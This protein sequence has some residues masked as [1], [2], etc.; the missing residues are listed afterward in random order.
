[1]QSRERKRYRL[2]SLFGLKPK[3][4]AS[5]NETT[6]NDFDYLTKGR[7]SP[8]AQTQ[9]AGSDGVDQQESFEAHEAPKND[10][11]KVVIAPAKST[12]TATKAI[13]DMN[14]P[15]DLWRRA[16]QDLKNREKALVETF[17]INIRYYPKDC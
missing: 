13:G 1:M 5:K 16:Y 7:L 11:Y 6:S 8:F 3:A 4:A 15:A 12:K 17:E 9:T 10:D 2:A 14:K